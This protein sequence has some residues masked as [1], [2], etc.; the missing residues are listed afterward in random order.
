MSEGSNSAPLL[1]ASLH[2]TKAL[3]EYRAKIVSDFDPEGAC[4]WG[5]KLLLLLWGT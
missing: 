4:I 2:G 5:I 1:M 3:V